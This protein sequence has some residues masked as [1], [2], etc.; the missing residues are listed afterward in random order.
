MKKYLSLLLALMLLASVSFAF[1]E[2]VPAAGESTSPFTYPGLPEEIHTQWQLF[3]TETAP[4]WRM[5]A[6]SDPE[7]NCFVVTL[8][9][10]TEWGVSTAYCGSWKYDLADTKWMPMEEAQP[11]IAP[12]AVVLY[13]DAE[14][15]Y[16]NGFPGWQAYSAD[17]RYFYMLDDYSDD[18]NNPDYFL[19]F[20]SDD[21]SIQYSLGGVGFTVSSFT[22]DVMSYGVYSA[23][24]VLEMASYTKATDDTYATYTVTTPD[25]P[26]AKE[27]YILYY[28]NVQTADGGNYLWTEG[29]WQ[30]IHGEEVAAP[31]GFNADELPFELIRP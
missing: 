4:E 22:E 25:D 2:A 30:D 1:A 26:E 11:D 12:E 29:A 19:N 13:M 5:T 23:E 27:D 7:T 8:F 24:G 3:A 10:P 20:I 14:E 16:M 17:E 31:D 28:I 21:A 15:Y 6:L 18:P 9:N